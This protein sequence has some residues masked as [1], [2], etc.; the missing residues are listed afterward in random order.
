M[1][2]TY[3]HMNATLGGA[4]LHPG[5]NLH[6]GANCAYEH[7]FRE[8]SSFRGN[9]EKIADAVGAIDGTSNE[10]YRPCTEPQDQFYSGNR[11][12]H[13]LHTQM[14]VD[15]TGIFKDTLKVSLW[16]L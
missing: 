2:T 14:V 4:N 16:V 3:W 10:I 6:P 5:G 8:W 9:W 12:Y 7:S 15:A 11:S 13:C 1:D